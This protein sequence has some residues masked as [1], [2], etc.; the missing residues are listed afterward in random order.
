MTVQ[1]MLEILILLPRDME[2]VM[3]DCDGEILTV[4]A[5]NS[6]IEEIDID[7]DEKGEIIYEDAFVLKVCTCSPDELIEI[8]V[9]PEQN[10]NLN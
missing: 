2:V 6:A 3:E 8:P 10:Q 5:V 7:E 9:V 1:T 4:C